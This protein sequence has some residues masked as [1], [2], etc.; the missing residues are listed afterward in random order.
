M[1]HDRKWPFT[2]DLPIKHGDFPLLFV[3]LLEGFYLWKFGVGFKPTIME[4]EQWDDI[5]DMDIP[6]GKR[7][8]KTMERSTILYLGKSAISMAIFNSHLKLPEDKRVA[9]NVIFLQ[10]FETLW[11]LGFYKHSTFWI[12]L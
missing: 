12:Q 2:V 5:Y 10:Q 8:Q 3:R 1:D 7:L 4:V 6:S 9:S 11:S